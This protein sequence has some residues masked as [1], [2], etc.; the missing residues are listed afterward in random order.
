MRAWD[1]A[2][3]RFFARSMATSARR[4][5]SSASMPPLSDPATPKESSTGRPLSCRLCKRACRMAA[6]RL[7]TTAPGQK[8]R[9]TNSSPPMRARQSSFLICAW[10]RWAARQSNVSPASWPK[11]SLTSFRPS[12]DWF[13]LGWL[14]KFRHPGVKLQAPALRS[15]VQ[16]PDESRA[17][18]Q[19][20]GLRLWRRSNF[21]L[22]PRLGADKS[23][24][25]NSKIG[26]RRFRLRG[27]RA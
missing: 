21:R 3:R 15:V 7:R 14:G 8:N 24:K 12:K 11:W 2:R 19:M 25:Q 23:P 18:R 6:S 10:S 20:P 27:G 22:K 17:V 1:A 26:E 4:N 9:M 13:W 16:R 5:S